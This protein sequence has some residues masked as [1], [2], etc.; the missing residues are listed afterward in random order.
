MIPSLLF[1]LTLIVFPVVKT[2]IQSFFESNYFSGVSNFVGLSNYAK[3]LSDPVFWKA[4]TVDLIWTLG[5]LI[6]QI[7]I[8]LAL[9]MLINKE[10]KAMVV[11]RTLLLVPY[12]IPVVAMALTFRWM[13]NDT[14][15]IVSRWLNDLGLLASGASLLSQVSTALP[16]VILINIYRSAPFAMICY[17]AALQSISPDI[18]EAS[19]IDG[20]CG[21][22]KFL[23]I[24]LPNLKTITLTLLIIRTIWNFNYYD[25]IYLLTQGGPA[26]STQHLPILIYTDAMGMFDFNTAS[27][28]SMLMGII[29][30]FGIFVYIRSFGREQE[31]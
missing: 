29:L 7:V 14:Y 13:L 4:L 10:G 21:W 31:A 17:W 1:L 3:V 22:K 24:T 23:Y 11:I 2:T 9:A 5:S 30:T 15:G 12:I 26:Q 8:G 19:S 27:T 6:G 18:Y 25:L 20:A 16:T 28:I